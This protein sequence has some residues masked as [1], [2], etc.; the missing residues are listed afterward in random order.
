MSI[1]AGRAGKGAMREHRA[2]K[3]AEAEARAARPN[4]HLIHCG[5]ATTLSAE[6]HLRRCG[7]AA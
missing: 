7:G 3:K 6:E 2:T 5:H 1:F 4:L